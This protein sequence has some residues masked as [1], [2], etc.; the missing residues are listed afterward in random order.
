MST[1]DHGPLSDAFMVDDPAFVI[2]VRLMEMA[3]DRG[4][5]QATITR[6]LEAVFAEI[7]AVRAELD[8]LEQTTDMGGYGAGVLAAC[9]SIRAATSPAPASE[10][11]R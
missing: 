10:E 11:T 7:D 3:E 2:P 9:E 6:T 5:M 1:G 4:L 8:R